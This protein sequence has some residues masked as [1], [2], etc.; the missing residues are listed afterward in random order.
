MKYLILALLAVVL[1]SG[2]VQEG[3]NTRHEGT[4]Y[5]TTCIDGVRYFLF[6]ERSG[7][8]GYGYM[9]PKFNRDGTVVTCGDN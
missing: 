6:H 5:R 3:R 9:S 1:L 7:Y 8:A 2:C 4:S